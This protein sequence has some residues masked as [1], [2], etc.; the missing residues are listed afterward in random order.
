MLQ[1]LDFPADFWYN[2]F[3]IYM[4]SRDGITGG[5]FGEYD[6]PCW[7]GFFVDG[8]L[9]SAIRKHRGVP[10]GYINAGGWSGHEAQ[11]FVSAGLA[12]QG[13]PMKRQGDC[14]SGAV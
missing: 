13:D 11:P 12:G 10:D 1:C 5:G 7:D 2:I 14:S 6:F 9:K 3:V 4:G 8:L